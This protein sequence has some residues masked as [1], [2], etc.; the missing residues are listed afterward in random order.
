MRVHTSLLETGLAWMTIP[1]ANYLATGQLPRKMGWGMAMM[2]PYEL[3]DTRD[4]KIFVAAANDRLFA[5]IC[6]AL[7]CPELASDLRF[8]DNPPRVA[9]R[10]VRL[11]VAGSGDPV[12]TPAP[13]PTLGADTAA[14]LGALGVDQAELAAL[15]AERVVG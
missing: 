13:P 2:A 11:P 7:G 15:R 10:A 9:H 1:I 12:R 14:V 8:V 4:G 5:R 3:F 6:D